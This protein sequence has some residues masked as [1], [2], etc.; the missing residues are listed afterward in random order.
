M[1][2]NSKIIKLLTG[3]VLVLGLTLIAILI[4]LSLADKIKASALENISG[5]VWSE[6]IGWISL[7]SANCDADDND[8]TDNFNYPN[9]PVGLAGWSFGADIDG[10][11]NFSGHIWSDN[12][13]WISFNESETGNPPSDDPCGSGC[14]ATIEPAGQLGKLDVFIKGWAR[15]LAACDSVPCV[16]SGPGANTGGWD[17]WIRF[18]HGA[19]GETY[20]DTSYKFHGWAWGDNNNGWISFNSGDA[21]AGGNYFAEVGDICSCSA[22][23]N[24]C[25]AAPCG[26]G[27]MK[28]TQVCNP[29]GCG[30]ET[31]C[32]ASPAC[33]HKECDTDKKCVDI[34]EP[35]GNECVDNNSCKTKLW[36]WWET[37]P[38]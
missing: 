28:R 16:S 17:G 33:S 15:A 19:S 29:P 8:V 5:W 34:L 6:N 10:A 2:K 21:G 30:V 20:I 9:C 3:G 23:D 18:D 13:G 22:T 1:K 32:L 12:V 4:D 27:E 35:G 25:A 36:R 38:K 24:G 37:I 26:A 14:I 31:L 11:G 7:N